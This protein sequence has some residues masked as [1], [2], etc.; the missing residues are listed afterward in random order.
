MDRLT[1]DQVR[2]AAYDIVL[3]VGIETALAKVAHRL[4][5]G[6]PCANCGVKDARHRPVRRLTGAVLHEIGAASATGMYLRR[7]RVRVAVDRMVAGLEGDAA[8]KRHDRIP[9]QR[10]APQ[11]E[12]DVRPR[13]AAIPSGR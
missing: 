8:P 12:V 10:R 4:K 11:E 7:Q 6:R 5:Y 1:K 2:H 3:F 13:A 9:R